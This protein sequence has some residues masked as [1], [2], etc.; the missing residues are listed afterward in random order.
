MRFE[1]LTAHNFRCLEQLR[2]EP[3]AGVTLVVGANGSGKTSV[4]EVMAVAALGKSFQPGRAGDIVR[5]GSGGLSV[6]AAL[7]NEAGHALSVT[8]R[9]TLSE[10]SIEADGAPI[11]AASQLAQRVPI[12]AL[13]SKMA[14]VLGD[15]PG[16]RRALIDRTMFHVEPAYIDAWKSYRQ[17]LRQRNA[18]LRQG[19]SVTVA[20]YWHD[21]MASAAMHIDAG[22]QRIVEHLNRWLE[23]CRFGAFEGG[24]AFRYLPGWEREPGLAQCLEQHWER[25]RRLGFTQAGVHRG[26]LRLVAGGRP[27][28]RRLSRGQAKYVA[29]TVYAAL[30]DFIES[31]SGM[32]PIMLID[33]LAAELDDKM[34]ARAVALIAARGGQRVFTAIRETELPELD[35][36]TPNVFHVEHD[37]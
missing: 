18:L 37:D 19:A 34:R 1:Q 3:A 22:R 9:K 36:E 26:D 15:S 5:H 14:D 31:E 4:L 33:D 12:V 8:V 30:S 11:R 13:G 35:D 28:V 29:V 20:E 17:G 23:R 27:V 21:A 7:R 32:K 6:R 10:T 25:D 16:N 24:F 2:L